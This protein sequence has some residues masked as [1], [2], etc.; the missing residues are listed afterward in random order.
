MSTKEKTLPSKETD[1]KNALAW[2]DLAI[3]KVARGLADDARFYAR[4][5]ASCAI[6]ISIATKLQDT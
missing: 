6:R 2:G 5:A 4:L 3:M 1:L